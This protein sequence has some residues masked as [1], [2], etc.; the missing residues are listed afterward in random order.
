MRIAYLTAGGAG[1]FCGSCMR[2]NTLA[3]ELLRLG[4]DVQLI[5]LYTPIRTDEEDV[6]LGKVFYGGVNV[7]LRETVPLLRFVP[8]FLLSWLDRP[9]VD[10]VGVAARQMHACYLELLAAAGLKAVEKRGKTCQSGPYNLLATPRWMLLVPRRKERF[11][12]IAVNALGFAGSLFVRDEAQ[13]VLLKRAGPMAVL[14]E[15]AIALA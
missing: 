10:D 2:D 6:S 13:L 1:M 8:R 5:P 15:T 7:Y 9:A 14:R 11:D 3:A 12:S 4:C